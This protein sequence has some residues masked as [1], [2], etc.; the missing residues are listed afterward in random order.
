MTTKSKAITNVKMLKIAPRPAALLVGGE[1]VELA[2]GEALL[3][4]YGRIAAAARTERG[5]K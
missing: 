4:I 1:L 5:R 2:P 3:M